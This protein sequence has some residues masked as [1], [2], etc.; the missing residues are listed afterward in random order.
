M[1]TALMRQ[2]S[3]YRK[4]WHPAISSHSYKYVEELG[5]YS[6]FL[7]GTAR[8]RFMVAI[9]ALVLCV[10]V[11]ASRGHFLGLPLPPNLALWTNVRVT[12]FPYTPVGFVMACT[13]PSEGRS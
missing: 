8:G 12:A 11:S 4:W 1:F 3:P 2:R 6:L 10:L 7:L 9:K 5:K 13:Q